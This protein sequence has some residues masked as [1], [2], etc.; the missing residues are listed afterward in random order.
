[1]DQH[2][3]DNTNEETGPFQLQRNGPPVHTSMFHDDVHLA[4]NRVQSGS[5]RL[6]IFRRMADIKWCQYDLAAGSANSNG[7]LAF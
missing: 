3:I 7:T 5:E 6:Q 1:M 2:C 4:T